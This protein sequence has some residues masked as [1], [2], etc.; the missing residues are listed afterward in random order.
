MKKILLL[1]LTML[2]MSSLAIAT[3]QVNSWDVGFESD[4]YSKY[5]TSAEMSTI[6]ERIDFSKR[7]HV[8]EFYIDNINERG[9]PNYVGI[10]RDEN[11]SKVTVHLS[12]ADNNLARVISPE[13]YDPRI[14][15]TVNYNNK[16]RVVV[17][18]IMPSNF[19]NDDTFQLGLRVRT[20]EG[21]NKQILLN[22]VSDY[23]TPKKETDM[24]SLIFIL[25]V[26]F[27]G[28]LFIW[29]FFMRK[30]GGVKNENF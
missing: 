15:I 21:E 1:I 3:K 17:S 19:N 16:R 29:F 20:E 6:N 8:F 4:Y 22:L 27:G 28:V 26:L 7:E 2:A 30:N 10:S 13:E 18:F 14:P 11:N 9:M 23:Q 5:I 24:T 12:G 25:S